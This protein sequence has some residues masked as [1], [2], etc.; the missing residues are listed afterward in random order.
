MI[1]KI[2]ISLGMIAKVIKWDI[3]DIIFY[4]ILERHENRERRESVLDQ[5][6][7]NST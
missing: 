4:D 7:M 3:L 1:F 5:V 6:S 2:N